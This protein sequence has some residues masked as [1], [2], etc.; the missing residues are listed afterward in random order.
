VCR[1]VAFAHARNVLHRDLKGHN[2][3]LGDFGEVFLLDWG[4]AKEAGE[5]DA[6]A[7]ALPTEADQVSGT[8]SGAIA[9]TPPFMAPEVARGGPASKASDISGLGGFLSSILAGRAPYDGATP[10]EVLHR[11]S[12]VEPLA[13]RAVT[14]EAPPALDAVCRTAMARDPA[15][16]SASADEL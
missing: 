1:A 2:V 7:A 5:P 8:H 10:E 6:P 14:P 9:G 16:R 13:P 3:V 4:L 12:A 15:G 11:V